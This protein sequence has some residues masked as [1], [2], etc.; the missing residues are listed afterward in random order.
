MKKSRFIGKFFPQGSDLDFFST[1]NVLLTEFNWTFFSQWKHY[2]IFFLLTEVQ[3]FRVFSMYHLQSCLTQ[4]VIIQEWVLVLLFPSN[5][6]TYSTV[7][8]KSPFP[9]ILSAMWPET[10]HRVKIKLYWLQIAMQHADFLNCKQLQE[11]FRFDVFLWW[12]N[13]L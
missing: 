6:I 10:G 8:Y 11:L 7:D 4:T 5:F 12:F 13:S 9:C 3:T 2:S 1:G